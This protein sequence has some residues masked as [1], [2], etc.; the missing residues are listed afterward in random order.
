MSKQRKPR[1]LLV[2]DSLALTRVYKEYLKPMSVN[3]SSVAEGGQGLEQ[4]KKTDPDVV[5][6]DLNLPDMNGLELLEKLQ[7]LPQDPTVVVITALGTI[8]TAVE[9]M[10]AGAFDFLQKPFDAERLRIT[11]RN[12]LEKQDLKA[13]VKT[14]R[15]SFERD[16]FHGFTGSSI[17]IQAVYRIIESAASSRASVFIT[18]ESGSGKE[19]CAD[20]IHREGTR[21]KKPFIPL[22][23]AA[24]PSELMESEIFGHV[25][26]AFTG[27]VG[28]R[29]GAAA[30][31][32]EGT[33]FLDEIGEM[34][35]ALQS[36]LLRFIQTGTFQQVGGNKVE[37]VDVRFVCATNRDPLEMVAKG[38]FREDLYYRLHVI[39]IHL[40]ALRECGNDVMLIAEKYL[41]EFAREEGKDFK[42]FTPEAA[43][44][45]SRYQWPGNVRQLQNILRN[46]VVLQNGELVTQDMLPALLSTTENARSVA[47]ESLPVEGVSPDSD[48]GSIRPLWLV[49]KET[50]EGAIAICDGNIPR[51]AGLLE[52]SPSTIYRKRLGWEEE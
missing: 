9:A 20:A 52:V 21:T 25:K 13:L 46:V 37:K 45:L 16:K 14:Y 50:I 22:N 24:I 5:L 29:K 17:P 27:A 11:V 12:A 36:K 2:E 28:E 38:T 43:Y 3:V 18:G 8:D 31:A 33:L 41:L 32:H 7:G 47:T 26:G 10:R 23:C 39:P 1:L 15:D 42:G 48:N 34:D 51:A 19:V 40:P 6:L 44:V 4:I 49:E 30:M 35:L